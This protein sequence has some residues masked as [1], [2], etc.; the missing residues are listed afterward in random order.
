M[1]M[2]GWYSN[3][4]VDA[5]LGRARTSGKAVLVDFWSSTCLGCAKMLKTTY[6]DAAVQAF[7]ASWFVAIKFDTARTPERFKELNGRS[8]HMWHP[9]LLVADSGLRDARRIVG[10]TSPSSFIAHMRIALGSIALSR[11]EYRIARDHFIVAANSPAPNDL[12]AEA[13]YWLGVA[14]YRVTGTLSALETVWSQLSTRFPQSD[15][16]ERADCLDVEIPSDGFDGDDLSSI[17]LLASAGI[18]G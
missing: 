11:R 18:S 3:D 6:T 17:R 16:A 5:A 14:E 8:L 2:N 4:D 1:S 12:T 13:L 7:V 9:H 15:W 10:R